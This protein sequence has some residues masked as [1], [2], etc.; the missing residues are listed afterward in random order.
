MPGFA[1]HDIYTATIA[2]SPL[3][4]RAWFCRNAELLLRRAP[5]RRFNIRMAGVGGV[6]GRPPLPDEQVIDLEFEMD[7]HVDEDGVAHSDPEAGLAINK[8]TFE[9][10]FLDATTDAFGSVEVEIEDRDGTVYGGRCQ[11]DEPIWGEGLVECSFTMTVLLIDGE[12]T[13]VGS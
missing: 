5:R 6:L 10:L 8:R 12:L 4:T 9:G 3:S 2:S 7:G 1:E 13:P 11:V